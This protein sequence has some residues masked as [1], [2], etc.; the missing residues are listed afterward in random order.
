MVSTPEHAIE[1]RKAERRRKIDNLQEEVDELKSEIRDIP[2][3]VEK[4]NPHVADAVNKLIGV[5][6]L[7]GER[8]DELEEEVY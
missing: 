1:K 6:E 7:Y 3:K 4:G 8:I 2:G 5:L